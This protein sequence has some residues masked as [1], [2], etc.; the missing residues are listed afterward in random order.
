M[1]Y[2]GSTGE[3]PLGVYDFCVHVVCV[4]GC[5]CVYVCLFSDPCACVFARLVSGVA[6]LGSTGVVVKV[7]ERVGERVCFLVASGLVHRSNPLLQNLFLLF[8]NHAGTA[9]W[10]APCL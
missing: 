8:R 2:K 10:C 1:A 5:A 4:C 6:G 9:E 7:V 3:L